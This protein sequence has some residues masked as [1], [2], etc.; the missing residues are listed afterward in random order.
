MLHGVCSGVSSFDV[1]FW[2]QGHD[3]IPQIGF[4]AFAPPHVEFYKA[5][6]VSNGG[7][8]A[9]STATAGG[10]NPNLCTS[11][12]DKA[13]PTGSSLSPSSSDQQKIRCTITGDVE[14]QMTP[15]YRTTKKVVTVTVHGKKRKRTITKRVRLGEL[16]VAAA[17]NAPGTLVE[18]RIVGF[19]GL[20]STVRYDTRFCAPVALTG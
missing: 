5:R 19:P 11:A 18:V 3:A 10:L 6:D 20:M 7:V 4:P 12:P 13:M 1:Y 17:A 14:L 2:P 15:L 16:A 8:L 9:A